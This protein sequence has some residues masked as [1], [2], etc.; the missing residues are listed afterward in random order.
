MGEK[1][2]RRAAERFDVRAMTEA[3]Q[4]LYKKLLAGD[5]SRWKNA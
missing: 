3:Y 4:D 5:R 1:S 2:A